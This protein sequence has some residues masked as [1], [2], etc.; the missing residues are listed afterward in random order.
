LAYATQAM[1]HLWCMPDV[2]SLIDFVRAVK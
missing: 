2:K 1:C